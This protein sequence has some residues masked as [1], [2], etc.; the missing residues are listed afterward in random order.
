M[1]AR[2]DEDERLLRVVERLR[3]RFEKR[4]RQRVEERFD[5]E[6]EALLDALA[7]YVT[8]DVAA[9]VLEQQMREWARLFDETLPPVIEVFGQRLIDDLE[10]G[11]VFDPWA[12][13]VQEWIR[14]YTAHNV[15][16]ISETTRQGVK[17]V[18]Q[19]AIDE[20]WDIP[21]T[22]RALSELYD[23]FKGRRAVLIART[24]VVAASNAGAYF[25]ARQLGVPMRKRWIATLDERTRDW[26]AEAHDQERDID[27]PFEV[28]GELLMFPGDATLGAS[29][30]NIIQCRC[31]VAFE[32]VRP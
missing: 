16:H 8:W 19:R 21:T 20:E 23:G 27:E 7:F 9:D 2:D 25:A 14:S 1:K 6:L 5:D 15:Q 12:V 32:Y 29:A 22:A 26:H 30:E 28:H 10:E 3:K 18:I 17:E 13:G 24:E 11:V 31:T 4:I